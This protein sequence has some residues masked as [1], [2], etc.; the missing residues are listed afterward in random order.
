MIPSPSTSTASTDTP[1]VR[2][3]LGRFAKGCKP[4]PGREPLTLELD[5]LTPKLEQHKLIRWLHKIAP[6][7]ERFTQQ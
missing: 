7:A 3:N 5:R 1:N 4:G 6:H 2:D